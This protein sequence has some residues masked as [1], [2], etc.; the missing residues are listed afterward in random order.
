MTLTKISPL[1]GKTKLVITV[2]NKVG[3]NDSYVYLPVIYNMQTLVHFY[4]YVL[5]KLFYKSKKKT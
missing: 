1:K 3:Y 4:T 5:P 2:R